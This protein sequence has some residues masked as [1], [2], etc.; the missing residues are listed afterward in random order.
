M[1]LPLAATHVALQAHW[2]R[3]IIRSHILLVHVLHDDRLLGTGTPSHFEV[4]KVEVLS[5]EQTKRRMNG[6]FNNDPRDLARCIEIQNEGG[7]GMA[8]VLFCFPPPL[9]VGDRGRW[10]Y[11]HERY[12]MNDRRDGRCARLEGGIRE[13]E[14]GVK[15]FINGIPMESVKDGERSAAITKTSTIDHSKTPGL[16]RWQ[17]KKKARQSEQED[18]EEMMEVEAPVQIEEVE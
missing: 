8:L 6:A 16:R 12:E 7:L 18:E 1:G 5:H 2:S 11:F 4:S 10:I 15:G 13:V 17:S 9:I 3:T 14:E